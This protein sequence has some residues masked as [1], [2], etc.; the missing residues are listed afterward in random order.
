MDTEAQQLAIE[1]LGDGNRHGEGS[2]QVGGTLAF[3]CKGA[4]YHVYGPAYAVKRWFRSYRA[5]F[6]A[7]GTADIGV[8]LASRGRNDQVEAVWLLLVS[9]AVP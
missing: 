2:L 9:S 8:G 6:A 5:V 1:I 3:Y 7:K 4:G